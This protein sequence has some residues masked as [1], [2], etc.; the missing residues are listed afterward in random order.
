M[1]KTIIIFLLLLY[2]LATQE[3]DWKVTTLLVTEPLR[4]YDG[5]YEAIVQVESGGDRFA[6]GDKHLTKYSYGIVQIRESRL[7]DYNRRANK[8]YTVKDLFSE[9]VS[10]EIFFYYCQG[11]LETVA[12]RWNGS[13][14]K[15]GIYWQ[16]VSALLQNRLQK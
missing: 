13:G 1:K 16:K 9:S 3:A 4:P 12:K 2:P 10:R 5:L 14:P 8:N 11:D 7:A 15:T 6:V